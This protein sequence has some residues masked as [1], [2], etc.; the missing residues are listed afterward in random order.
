MGNLLSLVVQL[1]FVM[2]SCLIVHSKLG[3]KL[4]MINIAIDNSLIWY[5]YW[6]CIWTWHV[7]SVVSLQVWDEKNNFLSNPM[8]QG[9]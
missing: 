2:L 7:V 4:L 1:Y 9:D 8:F 5:K 3:T 6:T